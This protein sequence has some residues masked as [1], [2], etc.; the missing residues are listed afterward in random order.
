[1]AGSDLVT[2]ELLLLVGFWFFF[3][4]H[5][6]PLSAAV[7]HNQYG[8]IL[9]TDNRFSRIQSLALPRRLL[10]MPERLHPPPCFS[11]CPA[12]EAQVDTW[13]EMRGFVCLNP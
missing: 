13:V 5:A 8:N 12:S 7:S 2:A 1:M 10:W 3:S 11:F 4:L 6:A 9:T